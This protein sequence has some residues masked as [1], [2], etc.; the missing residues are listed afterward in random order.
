MPN[1]DIRDRAKDNLPTVLL[2]LL[3]IVQ[4]L[5][6]ELMW[7]HLGQQD[8]LYTWSYVALLSWLQ[9]GASLLVVLLIWL[10][11]GSLVMRFRWVPMTSD[12]MF[13][14]LVGI[15]EFTLIATL[16]PS[17]LGQWFVTLAVLFGAMTSVSHVILRRARMDVENDSFFSNHAPTT[18]RDLY[19]P[20]ATVAALTV[21][22]VVLWFTGDRGWLAFITLLGATG[23]IAYQMWLNNFYWR[24]SMGIPTP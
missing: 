5:A 6:L 9:I 24:R 20:I 2:T 4:A 10:V 18:R 7:E 23:L 1:T 12:S 19:S 17:M 3:S 16:G 21:V 13:P 14:F 8:Y 11:Y 15:V 22:G